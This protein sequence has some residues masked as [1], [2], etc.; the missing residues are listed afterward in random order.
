MKKSTI[1]AFL[2]IIFIPI[3]LNQVKKFTG[4]KF[5]VKLL[6]YSDSVEIPILSVDTFLS[7]T[8][9]SDYSIWFE[10]NMPLRGVLTKTY[11]TIR[12]TFFNLGNR[13]IGRNGSVYEPAYLN[14]ELAIGMYDYSDSQKAKKIQDMVNHMDSV[15]NKLK[16]I[17]KYL[18]VYIAPS[19][20]DI[21][22][23]DMPHNYVVLAEPDA[24]NVTDLFREK[25][26]NTHVPY[27][28]CSD[29]ADE[30]VYPAFYPTGIHWSRTYE[31]ISSQR[32]INDLSALSGETYRNLDNLKEAIV[33]KNPFWRDSDVFNLLNV[34]SYPHIDYY[35]YETKTTESESAAVLNILLVGDSFAEGLKK[36]IE[37]NI[38]ED[39]VYFVSRNSYVLDFD[40]TRHSINGDWENF[41][42]Q[43]YLDLSDFVVIE[44]VEPELVNYTYSF[45]DYLDSY[46]D[47]YI[48]MEKNIYY[49]LE[50]DGNNEVTWN[51]SLSTG[52][53]AREDGFAWIQPNCKI[54]LSN[55]SISENGLEIDFT[56]PSQV[57]ETEEPNQ[58]EIRINGTLV[59]EESYTSPKDER[60]IIKPGEFLPNKKDDYIITI[61]CS[62][63]FNP[64]AIGESL[65]ERD[66]ALK[67]KYIGGV[68]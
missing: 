50:L 56:V 61:N 57:V 47:G 10:E 34:W 40:G 24:V 26:S 54:A 13:P 27:M 28:I 58:V 14:A 21:F 12:N 32:V 25:I 15:N 44:I 1:Y 43:S 22:P 6:G 59:Y 66:L 19:K 48:P 51:T 7:G 16:Q 45:I 60:I 29:I 67:L 8:F 38:V 37:E 18:Y 39:R 62:K 30:L 5:D 64:K 41:D 17:G 9:Q 36:D 11:N 23:E 68:K 63:Y 31:Q 46:L 33:S 53:W 3:T 49:A 55:R 20:A 2:L 65:D 52:V 4:V 42:W 35:Q